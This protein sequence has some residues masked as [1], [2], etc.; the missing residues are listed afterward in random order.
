MNYY[1][2]N[3]KHVKG[4][5][6]SCAFTTE[7]L[8][9]DLDNAYFVCRENA[10]DNSQVLFQCSIGDGISLVEYDEEKD[11]KKYAV[12]VAPEKTENLQSGTYY[13]DEEVRIN[14]DVFTI[15]RGIFILMQDNARGGN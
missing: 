13:Y 9:Q 15:M 4:D 1:T 14:G 7:G 3:I 2:N 10:N 5:T 8:G 12:R 6:F 11:I